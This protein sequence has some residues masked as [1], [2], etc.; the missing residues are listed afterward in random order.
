MLINEDFSACGANA[1]RAARMTVLLGAV[2]CL[3]ASA[4]PALGG[5]RAFRL[6]A[7]QLDRVTA[8]GF[9]KIAEATSIASGFGSDLANTDTLTDTSVDPDSAAAV[10]L[11]S[12]SA[13]D[14]SHVSTLV[15]VEGQDG[16][17]F[18]VLSSGGDT[19]AQDGALVRA[20][21]EGTLQTNVSGLS[22]ETG[23]GTDGGDGISI[24]TTSFQSVDGGDTI[25]GAAS[26]DG[27]SSTGR[28]SAA[29]N[30]LD[31]DADQSGMTL[32]MQSQGS[33]DT[34][35][36]AFAVTGAELNDGTVTLNM[37]SEGG[38][39]GG[40]SSASSSQTVKIAGSRMI[41]RSNG[42]ARSSEPGGAT[43][44]SLISVDGISSDSVRSMQRTI[45]TNRMSRSMS[46]SIIDL[47]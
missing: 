5:E 21:A 9:V 3:C 44:D 1:F 35:G 8:S 17:Q 28:P 33:G 7:R 12:A 20:G 2:S 43:S 15:I 16:T 40:R 47:R 38:A 18:I 27:Y 45:Q 32:K 36:S 31:Y 24:A 10:S 39:V 13:P 14:G 26:A 22:S 46:M 19:L 25:G 4:F 41:L 29:S 37:T 23:A 34:D 6:D 42:S 11:G 30:T